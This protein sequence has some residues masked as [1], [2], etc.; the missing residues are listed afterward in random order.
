MI[1]QDFS[2]RT[3]EQR[4]EFDW[5]KSKCFDPTKEEIQ[6]QEQEIKNNKIARC[7]YY[8]WLYWIEFTWEETDF[9]DLWSKYIVWDW[10]NNPPMNER[11]WDMDRLYEIVEDKK[12]NSN[13]FD[14]FVSFVLQYE[15]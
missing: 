6:K 2:S 10:I 9:S 7:K 12:N 15:Q 13:D 5:I 3:R 14:S 4:I 1:P 8:L 11:L